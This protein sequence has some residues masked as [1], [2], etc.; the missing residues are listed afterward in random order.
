MFDRAAFSDSYAEARGKFL[1]LY[2]AR[3][4]TDI[5]Y[6]FP[7]PQRTSW[8]R[9]LLLQAQLMARVFLGEV[10]SYWPMEIR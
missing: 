4:H 3:L 7:Q 5:E 1:T 10:K 2:E 6:P 9:V 8:R